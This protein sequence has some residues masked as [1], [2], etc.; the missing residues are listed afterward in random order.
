MKRIVLVL[1]FAILPLAG[2]PTT[3]G[4]ASQP[5]RLELQPGYFDPEA[6]RI[7]DAQEAQLSTSGKMSLSSAPACRFTGTG[8][9]GLLLRTG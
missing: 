9:G 5:E 1:F 6:R 7:P 2:C 4:S 3:G 8:S